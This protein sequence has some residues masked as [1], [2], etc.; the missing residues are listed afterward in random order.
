[1][2]TLLGRQPPPE[3]ASSL[4]MAEDAP[5]PSALLVHLAGDFAAEVAAVWPAPHGPFLLAEAA[6]RHLVCLTLAVSEGLRPGPA[7]FKAAVDVPL[8]RAVRS[9]LPDAPEGLARALAR[10]GEALWSADDYRLLFSRLADRFAGKRLR[11]AELISANDVRTLSILPQ[12]LLDAG[13]MLVT[14]TAHQARLITEC[15]QGLV[16]RDGVERV[17]RRIVRWAAA[18]SPKALFDLVKADLSIDEAAPFHPGTPRLRPLTTRKAIEDAARRYHNC[19]AGRDL[20]EDLH[21]YEWAGPPG[22][23]L[24]VR[25]D[26]LWG[27][28]LQEGKMAN[29]DEVPAQLQATIA[30]ELTIMGVHVGRNLYSLQCRLERACEENFWF[31]DGAEALD[32]AFG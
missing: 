30:E 31:G 15:Y 21:Y 28:V 32:H 24:C 17:Q 8:R 4:P 29:N 27:W 23:I 26:T 12:P 10:L 3:A 5:K 9:L 14:L 25:S 11:H 22:V 2:L 20:G 16:R 1:M 7:Q 19:L 6:R 13:G 18:P